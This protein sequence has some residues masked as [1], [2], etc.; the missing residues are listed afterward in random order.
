M[1]YI[2]EKTIEEWE[3]KGYRLM[4]G[5]TR[6]SS[7]LIGY[8]DGTKPKAPIPLYEKSQVEKK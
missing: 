8:A 3:A 4:K 2:I 1:R 7:H 5:V 6:P